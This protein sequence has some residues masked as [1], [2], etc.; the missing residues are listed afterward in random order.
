MNTPPIT[1]RTVTKK[2]KTTRGPAISQ[3]NGVSNVSGYNY[4]NVLKSKQSTDWLTE[5]KT[6]SQVLKIKKKT[7]NRPKGP[8]NWWSPGDEWKLA[9]L[10]PK[11]KDK[12]LKWKDIEHYFGGRS[13]GACWNKYT[14]TWCSDEN[15]VN[16]EVPVT[17][18]EFNSRELKQVIELGRQVSD[19]KKLGWT[20]RKNFLEIFQFRI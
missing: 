15:G 13:Y 1:K 20:E 16:L 10:I 7:V 18:F 3:K 8:R 2:T 17:E 14:R 12:T 4:V 19:G 11:V 5:G 9:M 6:C